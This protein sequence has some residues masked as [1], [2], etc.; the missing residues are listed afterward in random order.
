MD[1]APTGGSICNTKRHCPLP[2]RGIGVPLRRYSL[3]F[4]AL[5]TQSPS[6]VRPGGRRE[7]RL[8]LFPE[9][10]HRFPVR[11]AFQEVHREGVQGGEERV[12]GVLDKVRIPAVNG[13]LWKKAGEGLPP[14]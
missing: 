9:E 6:K 3:A 4:R 5:I 1:A 12:H 13:N 11:A 7:L 10:F 2:F 14:G 8:H